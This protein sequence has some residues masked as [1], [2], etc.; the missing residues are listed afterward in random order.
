MI[1]KLDF[2]NAVEKILKIN[3][4]KNIEQKEAIMSEKKESL[5]IVAGPG[6]GK[7]TAITLKI[8]KI[9]YIDDVSPSE[10][11]VTTFTKKAASELRSRILGWGDKLKQEFS[12]NPIYNNRKLKA[13]DFNHIVTG[14]LDSIVEEKL[15]EYREPG[16]SIPPVIENFVSNALMIN[17]GLFENGRFRSQ[18]LKDYIEKITGS[19][20]G[21]NVSEMSTTLLEIKD[22]FYHDRISIDNY[23]DHCK[24]KGPKKACEAINAYQ[25]ELFE[26]G[27]FDFSLLE[28]KFLQMLKARKLD[29]F[30]KNIKFL[31]VDEYQDTNLLQ[32]SIYFEIAK[33]AIE[34]GGS[35]TVVGDDDQSLYRFRGATVDL[36]QNFNDRIQKQIG[37]TTRIIWLHRNY[38]STDSV[39]NFCNNFIYLDNSYVNEARVNGKPKL[40]TERQDID[41][42]YHVLGMFRDNVQDLAVDLSNF[43]YEVLYGDGYNVKDN[44][45]NIIYTIKKSSEGSPG[46]IAILFNSPREFNTSKKV[47]LPKLLRDNLSQMPKPIHVFNPRGQSLE[48]LQE[49]Q[50]LCGLLLECIDKDSIIQDGIEKLPDIAIEKFDTW[51]AKAN[52]FI[53]SNPTPNEKG[54]TLRDFV[55]AWQNKKTL[56]G[57]DWDGISRDV[58]LMDIVY[59]LVTWIP[60]MQDDKEGIVYLEAVSRTITQA[61]LFCNFGSQIVFNET[62]V[63]LE[64]ASKKEAIRKIFVPIATGAI[65]INEDLLETIPNDRINIMSVH[66]AKGLEFPLIIVDVGS[67]FR[68]NNHFQAFKRFPKDGGKT[69]NMEDELRPYSILGTPHRKGIDRA[70]DDLI[71]RNFVSYSRAQDVL[72]LVGLNSVKNGYRVKA[73][74]REIPNI[75]T[76]WDRNGKWHW[77]KGLKNLLHI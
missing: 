56:D 54:K 53:I 72:L 68:D 51:R 69:C 67:E 18:D 27:I 49:V 63:E 4:K 11:V 43:L 32:E 45:N 66:Q 10:I 23:R 65:E 14:T 77:G 8:L 40:T 52:E 37:I 13:L 19:Y 35:I 31:L 42:D 7:T 22:R 15:G 73:G 33:K 55:K 30:L 44:N 59:K 50:I 48:D 57:K 70:F 6:S 25:K 20:Y 2:E 26:R 75:A 60:E 64:T 1:K 34:N 36:F 47:M 41:I 9:I 58:P 74:P 16:Q 39:V 24:D 3:L 76:G 38:R 28:D 62:N 29:N 46:D 12:N 21:L 61:T 17:A 5:F 71:R